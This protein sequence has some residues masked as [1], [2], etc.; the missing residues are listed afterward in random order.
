MGK[1]H[2]CCGKLVET[3][4]RDAIFEINDTIGVKTSHLVIFPEYVVFEV[5]ICKSCGDFYYKIDPDKSYEGFPKGL[6]LSEDRLVLIKSYE[7]AND[8][9]DKI[10]SKTEK[11]PELVMS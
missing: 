3:D 1:N 2:V 8:N 10:Y 11:Q 7:M 4:S 9:M 5:Y 6:V